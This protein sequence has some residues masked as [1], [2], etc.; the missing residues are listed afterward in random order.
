[1]PE[2]DYNVTTN[3]IME[4]LKDYVPTKDDLKNFAT[5]DDLKNFATKEDLGKLRLDIFDRFDDRLANLK[6]DLV[7]LM[8]KEDRKL[9][10]LIE[11][12]IDKQLITIDDAKNIF[13]MEPFPQLILN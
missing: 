10:S 2:I 13:K 7:I 1:M 8:R 6:G 3:E 11:L 4:Y 12:L 5:K 9:I